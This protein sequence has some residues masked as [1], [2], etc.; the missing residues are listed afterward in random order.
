MPLALFAKICGKVVGV[1]DGDTFTLLTKENK[2]I[3]IRLHGIDCPEK[4][5]DYGQ[6]A[7]QFTSDAIYGK[8]VC[9]DETD[10]DRYGRTIGIVHYEGKILNEELLKA[11]LAWH[12]KKYDSSPKLAAMEE[13]AH[14]QKKGLWSMASAIAPWE[15][16]HQ[17]KQY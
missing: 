5:Q 1:A 4:K 17:V 11:G 12:Y 10:I 2:Q 9:V 16:R 14:K 15:F 13:T 6:V 7:K 8:E 3:K